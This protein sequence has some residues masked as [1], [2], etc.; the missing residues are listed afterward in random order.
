MEKRASYAEILGGTTF[1]AEM[2]C[3]LSVFLLLLV[4]RKIIVYHCL[5]SLLTLEKSK[6]STAA[7][8]L[9]VNDKFLLLIHLI[10]L[11]K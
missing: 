5:S 3:F 10:E 6:A 8:L 9:F 1:Q 11:G 7:Q 2:R 4:Y